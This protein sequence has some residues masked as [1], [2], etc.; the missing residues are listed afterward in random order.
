MKKL[1]ATLG[2]LC[3]AHVA[4]EVSIENCVIVE[5]AP[6][7]TKTGLFFDV[8]FTVTDEVKALRLPSPEAIL[9]ADINALTDEIQMHNTEIKD[10]VM[11]MKRFPKLFLKKNDVTELKKGGTHFMLMDLKKRP[12]AGEQYPVNFWMTYLA[13]QRCEATVVK[14]TE[15][16]HHKS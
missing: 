12:L 7:V 3:S 5:P 11:T 16:Q 10:G 15:L 6:G 4:A 14:A 8:H 9:G 1:I 13:D 2:L